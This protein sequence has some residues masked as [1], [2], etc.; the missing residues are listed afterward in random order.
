[1]PDLLSHGY[2]RKESQF[3]HAVSGRKLSLARRMCGSDTPFDVALG[4]ALSDAF[5][6]DFDF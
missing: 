2:S 3:G 4:Q 1:L 5:D 6:L